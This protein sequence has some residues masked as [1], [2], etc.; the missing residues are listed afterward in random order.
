[1]SPYFGR[2]HLQ[3]QICGGD[4][5]SA[6]Y[7]GK[8]WRTRLRKKNTTVKIQNLTVQLRPGKENSEYVLPANPQ[9]R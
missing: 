6:S 4:W 1:M 3:R 5:M 8:A 2:Q 9:G 7:H